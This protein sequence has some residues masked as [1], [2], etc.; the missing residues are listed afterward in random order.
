MSRR[1][2]RAARPMP[3]PGKPP[4]YVS[5]QVPGQSRS[6]NQFRWPVTRRDAEAWLDRFIDERLDF[7]GIYEDAISTGT[8]HLY[9]SAITPTLNIGLL[10]PRMSSTA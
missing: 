9:H 10:D 1:P 4:T 2:N 5:R 6:L 7:F 3:S 8:R